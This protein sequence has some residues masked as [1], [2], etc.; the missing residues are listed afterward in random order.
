MATNRIYCATGL[1]G[2][3][4]GDLDSIK[5]SGLIDKDMAFAIDQTTVYV[6]AL[7]ADSGAA[8]SSPNVIKPNDETGDK[9]WILQSLRVNDITVSDDI[10]LV[11]DD[12]NVGGDL[13]ADTLTSY[14]TDTN[15][16]L[17][18]N[19]TGVIDINDSWNAAGQTCS[20]LGIVT[21]ADINGGS[22]DG[23]TIGAASATT[24]VGTTINA[25]T[26]F[27]VG[28]TVISDASILDD[29]LLTITT[30]GTLNF[31][32]SAGA[33]NAMN[34]SVGISD[35]VQ[36]ILQMRSDNDTSGPY[37]QFQVPPNNDG[38]NTTAWYIN[39]VDNADDFQIGCDNDVDMLQWLGG[40]TP[41]LK[42][43]CA[44]DV[45]AALTATTVDADTDFTVG[46]TKITSGQLEITNAAGT[47]TIAGTSETMATFVDD[48]AV[49]LYNNN[50]AEFYTVSNGGQF[51]NGLVSV[52]TDDDTSGTVR[53]YGAG[54]QSSSAEDLTTYTEY[55][56]SSD[57]TVTSTS[58]AFDTVARTAEGYVVYDFGA[59]Y[60]DDWEVQF[61]F[62]VSAV[63][64]QTACAFGAFSNT[65]GDMA[66]IMAAN[67]GYTCNFYWPG[68][69]SCEVIIE[70]FDND[71]ND[72]YYPGGSTFSRLYA[73]WTKVG[74]AI[75]CALYSDSGR[76]TLVDTLSLVCTE[77]LKRYFYAFNS[78]GFGAGV[79]ACTGDSSNHTF[80]IAGPEG[81][82]I[83]LYTTTDHDATIDSYN[84]AVNEDDLLIGPGTDADSLK[85]TGADNIWNFTGAAGVKIGSTAYTDA[86]ITDDGVLTLSTVTGTRTTNSA[87]AG[88]SANLYVGYTDSV[89]GIIE[90]A[91]DN[92]NAS[93]Y[94]GFEV[95]PNHDSSGTSKWIIQA[96]GST[97]DFYIG[98]VEDSD[99][100]K[101]IG[102]T[103]TIQ[104]TVA[105]DINAACTATTFD[106][107]T[108]FTV[109]GLVITSNT[110]TGDAVITFPGAS[111][112]AVGANES[113]EGY[114]SLYGAAASTGGTLTIYT[115]ADSDDNVDVYQIAASGENLNIGPDNDADLFQIL[116]G[117]T[118][119]AK[120]NAA[121]D[122][123][124]ALT[125][126]TV[127]ADTDFTVG[128]TVIT[129]GIITDTGIFIFEVNDTVTI[130]DEGNDTARLKVGDDS[131]RHRGVITITGDHSASTLGGT[132]YLATAAD[133]DGTG[134]T[135][136][137]VQVSSDDLQIGPSQLANA[138]QFTGSGVDASPWGSWVF[139]APVNFNSK[140]M[141]NVDI[142]SGAIDGT[143]IG[144]SSATTIKGTTINATTDVTLEDDAKMV[145]THPSADGK[146]CGIIL[147]GETVDTNAAGYG[148]IV[149][150]N[151]D[152]GHW[153]TADKDTEGAGPDNLIGVALGTT[154]S[155][156]V[157]LYGLVQ[158]DDWAWT[159][160]DQLFL[161]DDGDMTHTA[162]VTSGDFVR[163]M[164][165]AYDADTMFFN[166]SADYY[167]VA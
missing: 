97:D 157:L 65:L 51:P 111:G 84:I 117:V 88:S 69:G 21:T 46:N 27:T 77:T 1:I 93:P 109:G 112:I 28:G 124:A 151:S 144:A 153:D 150:L 75:T 122:V 52:G 130:K 89:R 72:K 43:N 80:M 133:H 71:T 142:D 26:S 116:G 16:T 134:I 76:T 100:L 9:R 33:G 105:F 45:D 128:G 139:N 106:A 58:V 136:F 67:D 138:L 32:N 25:G 141:T 13:T 66:D 104:A 132:M 166:P 50:V 121:V 20:D 4:T 129:D 40:G 158:E 56:P 98:S 31:T 70:D 119:T 164:G 83:N 8:Q 62:V 110:L 78:R 155:V 57:L 161:N 159:I 35:S 152:D 60:F 140:A 74:T 49:T 137:N 103:H 37:I 91:A 94:I 143:T 107:D 64:G 125:A 63:T 101:F 59:S 114:A 34:V 149:Y 148:G 68:G 120:F 108:D 10:I 6:Y 123:D 162:S 167:E 54:T 115:A 18:A 41:S 22:I 7:D 126:T 2:N 102:G 19:G 30:T 160:G 135:Y 82:A 156:D 39:V 38:D 145:L 73:T 14:T 48:G 90:M 5:G 15:L 96:V 87:G 118:P 81:G 3:G 29:G 11:T 86:T 154:G 44:F 55:D 147:Q 36:G 23:A 163:V 79:G 85:Y 12:L 17:A 42:A 53:V 131:S 95:A 113:V 127:D 47:F 99:M 61:D 24:I 146:A 165:H 92:A